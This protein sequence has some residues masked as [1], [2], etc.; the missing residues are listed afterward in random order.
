MDMYFLN[1]YGRFL[2]LPLIQVIVVASFFVGGLWLWFGVF[3]FFFMILLVDSAL[4]ETR[5]FIDIDTSKVHD[6][7][8]VCSILLVLTQVLL[9]AWYLGTT[10][11]PNMGILELQV[12]T[13]ENARADSG[14]FS[15][16]GAII[17]TAVCVGASAGSVG[18]ELSHR[19]NSIIFRYFG[20]WSFSLFGYGPYLIEHVHG[21]HRQIGLAN[22]SSTAWRGMNFW[23]YLCRSASLSHIRSFELEAVRLKNKGK[24]RLNSGNRVFHCLAM[25]VFSMSIF[26][27][28]AGAIGIVAFLVLCFHSIVIIETFGYI[29]H[30]GLIREPGAPVAMRHSWNSP[31]RTMSGMLFNLSRHSH[32]HTDGTLEYWRLQV[33]SSV[34]HLPLSSGIVATVAIFPPLFFRLMNNSLRHWDENFASV[35]ERALISS[36]SIGSFDK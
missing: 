15:K 33:P 25:T 36:Q 22:D 14:L 8:L 20:F 21:H 10:T 13:L 2:F 9:L 26:L 19:T 34:P 18:H 4:G 31:Q 27:V 12:A 24:G 29:G 5:I 28:M 6:A 3:C 17:S 1:Q 32:H 23:R 11:M 16:Y 7:I 35:G 30:Y